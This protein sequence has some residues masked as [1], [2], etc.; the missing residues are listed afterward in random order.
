MK[1]Y[2]YAF[3]IIYHST[4]HDAICIINQNKTTCKQTKFRAQQ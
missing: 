1:H 3:P 2:V 4:G